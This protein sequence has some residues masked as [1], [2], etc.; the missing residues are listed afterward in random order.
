MNEELPKRF[1]VRQNIIIICC[2]AD[3][4]ISELRNNPENSYALGVLAAM[5]FIMGKD[6]RPPCTRENDFH[7]ILKAFSDSESLGK[8]I[9]SSIENIRTSVVESACHAG[10]CSN[11]ELCGRYTSLSGQK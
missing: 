3:W 7:S 8:Y 9:C 6:D 1:V 5:N 11:G 4:A 2:I 10:L